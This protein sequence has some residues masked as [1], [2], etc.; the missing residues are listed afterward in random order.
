MTVLMVLITLI[1]SHDIHELW[2]MVE[3]ESLL[4]GTRA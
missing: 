4:A 1:I 3:Q 2:D